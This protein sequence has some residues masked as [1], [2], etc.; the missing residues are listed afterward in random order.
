MTTKLYVKNVS[1]DGNDLVLRI[2]ENKDG[3]PIPSHVIGMAVLRQGEEHTVT[4]W[5]GNA[6]LLTELMSIKEGA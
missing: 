3:I 6:I 5:A 2:V 4:V 1:E